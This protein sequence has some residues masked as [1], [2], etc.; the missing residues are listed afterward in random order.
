[1]VFWPRLTGRWVMVGSASLQQVGWWVVALGWVVLIYI[2]IARSL[3]H[4]RRM[5]G[6]I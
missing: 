4:R 1:M 3:Y 2:V 5:R 6:E